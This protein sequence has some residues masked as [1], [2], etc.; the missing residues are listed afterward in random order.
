MP[1]RDFFLLLSCNQIHSSNISH[2]AYAPCIAHKYDNGMK[3]E[4]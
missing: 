3:F 2:L 1:R 4:R